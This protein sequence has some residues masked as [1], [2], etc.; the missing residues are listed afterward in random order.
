MEQNFSNQQ[1]QIMAKNK[2]ISFQ[3]ALDELKTILAQIESESLNIDS[4]P[5]LVTRAKELQTLC[6]S[7][8]L[9]IQNV[10]SDNS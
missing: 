4:I 3:E 2:E 7:K 1:I 5:T 9:A 10:I 6:E 8:L